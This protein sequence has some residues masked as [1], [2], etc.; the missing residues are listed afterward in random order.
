LNQFLGDAGILR[1]A[2][3]FV[4]YRANRELGLGNAGARAIAT[5]LSN[6][7]RAPTFQFQ[8]SKTVKRNNKS[9]RSFER[10]E[11]RELMAGNVTAAATSGNLFVTGDNAANLLQMTEVSGNRWKITGLAGTK[12]SGR[13]R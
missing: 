1:I 10:L 2:R 7:C 5:L 8:I 4:F 9:I 12:V 6:R 11:L 3:A 13:S